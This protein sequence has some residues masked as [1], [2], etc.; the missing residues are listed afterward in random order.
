M[1]RVEAAVAC[2][3]SGYC[4]SQAILATYA[5]LFA[6]DRELALKLAA[7]FG[8]GMGCTADTCGAVTGAFMVLGLRYGN[9]VPVRSAK[10]AAYQWVRQ[11]SERFK[12]RHGSL[13]CRDLL[14]C[15]ISTPEGFQVALN[16][17]LF[18]TVCPKVVQDA[19]EILEE[20]L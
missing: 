1:S 16:R 18:S 10:E 3:Q 5:E 8:G 9:T 11:F 12:G 19:A 13:R 7:G 20:L 4:C 6:L 15:D 17:K 14:G 2:F